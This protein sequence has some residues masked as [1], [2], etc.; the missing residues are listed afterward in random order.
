M[1]RGYSRDEAAV[2]C[3]IKAIVERKDIAES[4]GVHVPADID[5]IHGSG[6]ACEGGDG[7]VLYLYNVRVRGICSTSG[8]VCACEQGT[9]TLSK[10]VTKVESRDVVAS[11]EE[12]NPACG[13]SRAEP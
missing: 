5:V 13:H 11:N 6:E 12:A 8:C 1:Y 10:T 7:T 2:V 4:C 3:Q 9:H